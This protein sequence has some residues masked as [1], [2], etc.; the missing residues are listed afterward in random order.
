MA[1]ANTPKEF[2]KPLEMAKRMG[3]NVDWLTNELRKDSKRDFP[4]YPFAIATYNENTHTWAYRINRAGF[5]KWINGDYSGFIDVE[6]FADMVA[7]RL[8]K[9][10]KNN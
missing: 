3:K 7:E 1:T 6:R 8:L 10:M 9:Q 5:E 2:M 4:R